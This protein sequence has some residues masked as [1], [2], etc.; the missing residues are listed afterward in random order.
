M[1]GEWS[2]GE[3]CPYSGDCRYEVHN[4]SDGIKNYISD[5][6]NDPN[7]N[8]AFVL[9]VGDR[10]DVLMVPKVEGPWDIHYV[11]QLLAQL[12]ARAGVGRSILV[13]AI[14]ETAPGVANVQ[15]FVSARSRMRGI[16]LGPADLAAARR[17]KTTRVGG[18]PAW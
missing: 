15:D 9:L 3:L 17:I 12:E 14:L 11:D 5:F 18:G 7:N 4:A 16:S 6:Y 1:G 10:P 8:L 2:E 13:H